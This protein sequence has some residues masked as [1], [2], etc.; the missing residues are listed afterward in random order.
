MADAKIQKIINKIIERAVNVVIDSNVEFDD[1]QIGALYSLNEYCV[2]QILNNPEVMRDPR[3]IGYMANQ[4]MKFALTAICLAQNL[5]DPL[6]KYKE[7]LEFFL[8]NISVTTEEDGVKS[9]GFGKIRTE[10]VQEAIYWDIIEDWK[11]YRDKEGQGIITLMDEK[12]NLVRLD[13]YKMGGN[14]L[15]EFARFHRKYTERERKKEEKAR[16]SAQ[17]VFRNEM[18]KAVASHV[19]QQQLLE[20]KNPMEMVELLFAPQKN[21][22][23]IREAAKVDPKIE[24][25]ILLMLEDKSSDDE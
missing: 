3:K 14:P 7:N 11:I 8:D 1:E 6:R 4:E 21:Q 23:R 17:E 16:E 15:Y 13:G 25:N 9:L 5:V 12:T 10:A 24:Q 20:G 22:R 18:V 19:A 2:N